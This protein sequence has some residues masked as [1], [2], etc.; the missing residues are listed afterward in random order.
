MPRTPGLHVGQENLQ[1]SERAPAAERLREAVF[2]SGGPSQISERSQVPLGTLNGYLAGGEMK[3]SNLVRLARACGVSMEWIA[4]GHGTP[5]RWL[6]KDAAG[7]LHSSELQAPLVAPAI[8]IHWLMKAIEI[9]EALG[10]DKL[11]LRERAQR[12]ANGYELLTAPEG[13]IPPLPPIVPR[14]R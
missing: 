11:P 5:P 14:G 2:R 3:V 8:N 7:T 1:L 10:G 13:D 6:R 12:I 9:V 4:T